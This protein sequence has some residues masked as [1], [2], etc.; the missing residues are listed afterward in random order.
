MLS[1]AAMKPLSLSVPSMN[2]VTRILSAIEQ[3][4]T[5]AA[6]QLLPLVY[7]G[8]RRLA[9]EIQQALS[10]DDLKRRYESQGWRVV[11]DP[12]EQF[13]NIIKED[14]ATWGSVIRKSGLKLD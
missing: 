5:H 3:G 13:A 2:D 12:P 7:D 8:L 9:S 4:D 6:E 14:H 10:A 11:G 1:I